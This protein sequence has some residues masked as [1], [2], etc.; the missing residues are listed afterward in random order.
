[1]PR[2]W[3]FLSLL[4][5]AHAFVAFGATSALAVGLDGTILAQQAF[6]RLNI[7]AAYLAGALIAW[8][9]VG[10]LFHA[11]AR[12][13]AAGEPDLAL[14]LPRPLLQPRRDQSRATHL[15]TQVAGRQ[16]IASR[17]LT[18][19]A[20]SFTIASKA[21]RSCAAATCGS[22]PATRSCSKGPRA[23]A[24]RRSRR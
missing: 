11:A 8:Q 4:M 16:A 3:L 1:V 18:R 2:G 20:W 21:P 14:A 19:R 15:P 23:G 6:N 9:R 12:P 7:G 13:V 5:L 17:S 10:A 24:S 22:T